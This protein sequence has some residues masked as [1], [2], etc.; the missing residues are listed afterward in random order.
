[1][2]EDQGLTPEE[3]QQLPDFESLC[4]AVNWHFNLCER[5]DSIE[6]Y[7]D[8]LDRMAD[9]RAVDLV[10]V[11][12]SRD[13]SVTAGLPPVI[14]R[15]LHHVLMGVWKDGFVTGARFQTDKISEMASFVVPDSLDGM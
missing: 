14:F 4:K 10:A 8:T 5:S 15:A 2:S 11:Y 7:R 3:T 9:H 6:E 13:L 1:M 12:R